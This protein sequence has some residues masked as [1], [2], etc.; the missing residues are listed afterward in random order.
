MKL[1]KIVNME[2]KI[3]I[4]YKIRKY[5]VKRMCKDTGIS[6]SMMHAAMTWKH[7]LHVDKYEKIL[8]CL[9]REGL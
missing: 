2:S 3:D 5:G 4:E 1:F 9:R 8:E 6:Y 7:R